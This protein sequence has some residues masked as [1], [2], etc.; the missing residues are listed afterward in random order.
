MTHDD[1]DHEVR[2]LLAA[3]RGLL[4]IQHSLFLDIAA[5]TWK[6]IEK[7]AELECKLKHE[8]AKNEEG[9]E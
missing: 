4:R 7:C 9:E 8:G 5:Q 3:T 1:L 6:V 2:H